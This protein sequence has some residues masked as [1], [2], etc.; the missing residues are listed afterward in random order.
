MT[1][2]EARAE[3]QR[4]NRELGAAGGRAARKYYYLETQQPDGDWIVERRTGDPA[5]SSRWDR[6]ID[7]FTNF[8]P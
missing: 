8:G 5:T 7:F 6:I 1:E 4:L 2:D 3:A